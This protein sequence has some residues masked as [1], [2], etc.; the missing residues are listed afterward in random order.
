MNLFNSLPT[1]I[2]PQTPSASIEPIASDEAM[3]ILRKHVAENQSFR[4]GSLK[5][6]KITSINQSVA[7]KYTLNRFVIIH[8]VSL[9]HQ[10]LLKYNS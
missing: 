9:T 6:I 4:R 10:K 2:L 3:K 1:K 5:K 7:Y 8:Y